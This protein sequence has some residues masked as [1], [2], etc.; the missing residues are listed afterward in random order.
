MLEW[1]NDLATGNETI[2]L[3]HKAMFEKAEIIFSLEE[4]EVIREHFNFFIDYVIEHFSCEERHMI[5]ARYPHFVEHR[6]Q[7]T[8]FMVEIFKLH[9]QLH[10][11]AITSATLTVFK[12]LL[13]N[14]LIDH[15]HTQDRQFAMQLQNHE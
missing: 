6:E 5:H 7:H 15:I 13:V 14:W 9:Q 10:T 12:A 11:Q 2:D 3:Q 8:Y 1:T 4:P